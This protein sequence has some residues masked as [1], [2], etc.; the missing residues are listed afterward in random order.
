MMFIFFSGLQA[1]YKPDKLDKYILKRYGPKGKYPNI[2]DIPEQ[3]T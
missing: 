2:E 1:D 3:V